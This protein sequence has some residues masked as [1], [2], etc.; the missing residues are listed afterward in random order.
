MS[1]YM[2]K[3][4]SL[5][6]M[7][8]KKVVIPPTGARRHGALHIEL[9]KTLSLLSHDDMLILAHV[10][11]AEKNGNYLEARV[12]K[13]KL[14]S[15]GKLAYSQ[16]KR[17]CRMGNAPKVSTNI[18]KQLLLQESAMTKDIDLTVVKAKLDSIE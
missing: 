7:K 15:L 1:I 12:Y 16:A 18:R 11:D 10:V 8:L 4:D 17:A 3:K 13:P 6:K 2:T 14:S 5:K 9:N